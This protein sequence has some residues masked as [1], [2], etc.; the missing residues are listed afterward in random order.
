MAVAPNIHRTGED[1]SIRLNAWL[2]RHREPIIEP[3]LPIVDPHHH[4][5]DRAERYLL[6][7]L[8]AD[9]GSGH[10][11]R[12]TVFVQCNSMYRID[13]EPMLR[14][15]G[16]TEF[17]NGIAAMA[18]SGTYGDVRLC[19]GIVG[20][21]DLS[22]GAKVQ[23]V[24][25]AHLRIA[26]DRFRGIRNVSNWDDDPE[27]RKLIRGAAPR[28][29]LADKTFHEGFARLRPLGL[30]FD[31]WTY[32]TQLGE[33]AALA[34]AFPDTTIV[35]DHVGGFLGV[36]GYA[37][38]REESFAAWRAAIRNLARRPNVVVKLGGLGM[39]SCGFGLHERPEPPSSAELAELWRPFIETCIEAFGSDRG[40]F[41]SNF[42]VD[43]ASCSYAVLWNALKRIAASCSPAEK[44]ALFR[45]TAIRVYRLAPVAG[46]ATAAGARA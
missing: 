41:E 40:M 26:G 10:D 2:D 6:D 37:A 7:E 8:L 33:V 15:L 45:D 46:A 4:V 28:G 39:V 18:A 20:Y 25:E 5:W 14:P 9:V 42:P 36:G 19:E 12:S 43:K 1:P 16:E 23:D 24:L 11:V 44:A 38:R 27:V 21:A 22:L 29:L 35:L 34:D 3:E 31:V 30:T 32:F 13:G 17:V